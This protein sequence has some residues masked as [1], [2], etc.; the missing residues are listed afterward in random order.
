MSAGALRSLLVAY[1][2]GDEEEQGGS[3]RHKADAMVSTEQPVVEAPDHGAGGALH[4]G[5]DPQACDHQGGVYAMEL[6]VGPSR[7]PA[8]A[9]YELLP[10]PPPEDEDTGNDAVA[11]ATKSTCACAP[12]AWLEAVQLPPVPSESSVR[13]ELLA[14]LARFHAM[15]ASGREGVNESLRRS[16]AYANPDFVGAAAQHLGLD[17]FSTRF[18]PDSGGVH[19]R[20]LHPKDFYDELQTQQRAAQEQREVERQKRNA[21]EFVPQAQP[22]QQ[23]QAQ[24]AAFA[25]AAA[26]ARAIA[27]RMSQR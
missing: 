3:P 26:A 24:T 11:V 15:V 16:K 14:K 22:A 19:L 27:S 5:G 6:D 13:P 20:D 8:T 2:S 9:D 12:A 1:D 23:P 21:V 17:Q 18:P 25:S 4:A 7:P 10:E